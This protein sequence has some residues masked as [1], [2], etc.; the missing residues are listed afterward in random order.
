[1]TTTRSVTISAK[2]G[3]TLTANLTVTP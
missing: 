2:K 1:V 3:A